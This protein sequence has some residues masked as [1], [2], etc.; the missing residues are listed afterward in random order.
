MILACIWAQCAGAAVVTPDMA[1]RYAGRFMGMSTLPVQEKSRAQM[2]AGRDGEQDAAYYVYNNPD[3]GWVIIAADDRINPVLGYSDNGSFSLDD[4][5]DNLKWWMAG[6]ADAVEEVRTSGAEASDAARA[7]W[8]SLRSDPV[9]PESEQKVLE[10]AKWYQEWPYNEKCPIVAG[11]N[12]R[13]LTGCVATAMAIIMRYNRWP[14]RGKGLIGGYVTGTYQTYIPSFYLDD[15]V[16]DWDNM[17]LTDGETAGWADDQIREVSQLIYDCGVSVTMDYSERYGSSAYE[18]DVPEAMIGNFSYSDDIQYLYR[19]A[20][21]LNEWF[22]VMRNEI[23]A[24]RLILYCGSSD[25]GGHA[26]VCDGYDAQDSRLHINWGWG[27]V[28]DG[29]YTLDLKIDDYNYFPIEQTAIIGIVPDTCHVEM[30]DGQ[31]VFNYG[32]NNKFGL[33]P[34]DSPDMKEGS[35]VQFRVGSFL[36]TSSESIKMKFKVCL[37]DASGN[38]RQEG[39]DCSFNLPAYN[40]YSYCNTSESTVLAVTPDLTDCFRLFVE[41]NSGNWIPMPAD[42]DLFPD[43]DGIVCGV[44]PDPMIVYD[45]KEKELR[46][47]LG[48]VPVKSVK[49]SINGKDTDTPKVDL[50]PGRNSVKAYVEY[51]DG[52]EGTIRA[53]FTVK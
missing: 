17:P 20:Y 15:H 30:P 40:G 34:I 48:Y 19:S 24:E 50:E 33:I 32:N 46:L 37:M 14:E 1:A 25:T 36:N 42:N 8:R 43:N 12:K 5:P 47:T 28:A 9:T 52:T 26:F 10:T 6:L 13:A 45:D 23:D 27:G 21:S 49:W 29:Y 53:T 16:Y 51:M 39:W 31:F 22:T 38:L 3:G 41:D 44:T 11:E 35:T 7:A 18:G 2:A 4:M